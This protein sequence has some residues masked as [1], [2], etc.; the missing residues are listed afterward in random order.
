MAP[1][2]RRRTV[3]GVTGLARRVLRYTAGSPCGAGS[4]CA[5]AGWTPRAHGD[6]LI[7]VTS[8][9]RNPG[10]RARVYA[11]HE[12]RSTAPRPVSLGFLPRGRSPELGG[13]EDEVTGRPQTAAP[14]RDEIVDECSRCSVEA[15]HPVGTGAAHV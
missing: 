14:M 13:Q 6:G 9:H 10:G 8:D 2:L 7:Y 1:R 4:R 5:A 15:K 3:A 12:D 11:R